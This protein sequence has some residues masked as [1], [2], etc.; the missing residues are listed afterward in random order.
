MPTC[1]ARRG[2]RCPRPSTTR[3]RRGCARSASAS[4]L[5]TRSLTLT[6]TSP[7]SLSCS[8]SANSSLDGRR[9]PSGRCAG[10]RAWP[11]PAAARWSCASATPARS[12]S[13]RGARSRACRRRPTARA[14]RAARR[15]LVDVALHDAPARPRAGDAAQVDALL[16]ARSCARTATPARARARCRCRS[17]PARPSGGASASARPAQR[18]GFGSALAAALP[19]SGFGASAFAAAGLASAFGVARST[20]LHR[21]GR[22]L[23][24]LAEHRHRIARA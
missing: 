10:S 24:R 23:T 12:W 18:A 5:T 8:R 2:A 11:R 21:L 14:P 17:P 7:S 4:A 13:S 6:L 1:D 16:A 20:L 9:R 3:W 19:P 22:I 15:R